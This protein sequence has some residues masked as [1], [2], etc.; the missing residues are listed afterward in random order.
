[1]HKKMIELIEV[2]TPSSPY[3][4]ASENEDVAMALSPCIEESPSFED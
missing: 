4:Q 2:V 1:M 3:S